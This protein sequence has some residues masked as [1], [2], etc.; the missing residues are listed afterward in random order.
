M[1]V[2]VDLSV[3]GTSGQAGPDDH[4]AQNTDLEKLVRAIRADDPSA[5]TDLHALLDNG[6]RFFLVRSLGR[7]AEAEA[8]SVFRAILAA[9][10]RGELQDPNALAG[11]ALG[12]VKNYVRVR[13]AESLAPAA[14]GATPESRAA[15]DAVL[16]GMSRR[17]RE[18]L[19][20]FYAYGQ[21]PAR[22]MREMLVTP[23]Q[24]QT[25]RAQARARFSAVR[26]TNPIPRKPV[27]SVTPVCEAVAIR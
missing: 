3:I 10:E 17:D 7:A 16:E 11:F 5:R 20:R 2:V 6:I 26:G 27:R 19:V 15:M 18:V 13:G 9:I 12:I 4:R 22:I 23:D 25:V 21:A 14:C 1:G 8:P 24:F